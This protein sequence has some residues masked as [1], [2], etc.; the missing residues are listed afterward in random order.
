MPAHVGVSPAGELQAL[1]RCKQP[2]KMTLKSRLS[3]DCGRYVAI[4]DNERRS[5]LWFEMR[6]SLS[7]I[8]VY[9]ALARFGTM[10]VG[11]QLQENL[12]HDARQNVKVNRS[13]AAW[14]I[15]FWLIVPACWL[16]VLLAETTPGGKDLGLGVLAMGCILTSCV[17]GFVAF[18]LTS[19]CVADYVQRSRKARVGPTG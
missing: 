18:I 2:A 6:V 9:Q 3:A 8:H 15:G 5:R 14:S 10:I 13:M 1:W 7:D 17:V 12:K 16:P 4:S 19:L 11:S